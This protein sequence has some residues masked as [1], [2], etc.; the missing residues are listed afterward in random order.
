MPITIKNKFKIFQFVY[1]VS[2]SE[3][4]R[5]QIVQINIMPGN[6]LVYILSCNA[7]ESE[8]YES[9]LSDTKDVI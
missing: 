1:V 7:E 2:D 6:E 5:R 3:Q 8:H 4:H 9:E